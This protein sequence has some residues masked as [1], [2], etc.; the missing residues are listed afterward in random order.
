[1]ATTTLYGKTCANCKKE[2]KGRVVCPEEWCC[3]AFCSWECVEEFENGN[4]Y[5]QG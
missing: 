5:I 2:I 4:K 1:M 3:L